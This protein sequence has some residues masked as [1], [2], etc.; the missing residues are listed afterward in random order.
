[1]RHLPTLLLVAAAPAFS[2][3][4]AA[5]AVLD[6]V[7]VTGTGLERRMA[8]TPYAIEVVDAEQ[9][10][11]AG[12]LVNLSESLDRVPGL[13]A[14]LRHNYAQDLQL[15][16]RGFGARASFGV[17]GLRLYT[18]GIPA[19]TPDGQGQVSHFDLAGAERLEVLRGPF[20]ALHGNAAG[21]VIALVSAPVRERRFNAD[22]DAGSAGLRQL[23]VGIDAPLATGL[24]LR[25]QAARFET[26][27]FRSH[28]GARRT[29]ANARLGWRHGVDDAVLLVNHLEQPAD[30]P[31]GLTRAQLLADP[32]QT[33]PQALQFDTRKTL[34]QSQ[35]GGRWTHRLAGSGDGTDGPQHLTLLAYAGRRAVVQWQ[36]IPVATQLPA[37]HPGGVIDFARRYHG[38]DARLQWRWHEAGQ[39]RGEL[40]AGINLERQDED[41]RGFENFAGTGATQ[42]LGVTGALRRQERG[43]TRLVEAYAQGEATLAPDWVAT[44]GARGGRLEQAVRDEFLANGDASGA[45]RFGYVNPVAALRWR[46]AER[47]NVYASAGRGYEAPTLGEIA[48]RADG[49]AGFNDQ[50][51]A[52]RSRQLELGAKWR[53]DG[54]R[55]DAAL[56][57]ARSS[58]E[59]AVRSN[60][61]GRSTFHNVG[62]TTRRGLELAAGWQIAREWRA[63][64]AASWLTARY[65]DAFLACG[66]PPCPTPNIPVPAGA[67]IA[68]TTPRH[69]FAELAWLPRDGSALA[70]EWRGQGALTVNDTN[71]ERAPG[72]GRWSL[73]ASR[74]FAFGAAGRL[75]LLA[76]VDNLADRRGQVASVIVNEANG[77]FY[78]P[79]P[80]RTWL[81]SAR[82]SAGF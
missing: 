24:D 13:N 77:R 52:Q 5:P 15:A 54:L 25:A 12:P 75:E 14:R 42:R 46:A 9:L 58:D 6:P 35:L 59:I 56:F 21:G 23:R 28:S 44:L 20:T 47:F 74:G 57:D 34:A 67:R 19:G 37:S 27:G 53:A 50:L 78:E 1:M 38:A 80:G 4:P 16:S 26:D 79:A 11:A 45:R 31:L 66:A 30:D 2:A 51:R 68:G 55:L 36:A 60:A 64:L 32:A 72:F 41:R 71:T 40:I 69:G 3:P 29:L 81:L 18:D 33:A 22:V 7:V 17:R 73:R 39:V 10:R 65:A 61:G 48:Y 70:L 82:W 63:G 43:A 49:G 8:E 76:R 62:R